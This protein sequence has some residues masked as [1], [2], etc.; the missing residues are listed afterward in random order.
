MSRIISFPQAFALNK[1]ANYAFNAYFTG[2]PISTL[3]RSIGYQFTQPAFQTPAA[4]LYNTTVETYAL[5]NTT[6][7]GSAGLIYNKGGNLVNV[8][9]KWTN[10]KSIGN[11]YQIQRHSSTNTGGSVSSN[12]KVLRI[13]CGDTTDLLNRSIIHDTKF[14][15]NG[16]EITEASNTVVGY[17]QPTD[18]VNTSVY[19]KGYVE[20]FNFN[21]VSSVDPN[22]RVGSHTIF[23]VG[24]RYLHT[25][26]SDGLLSSVPLDTFAGSAKGWGFQAIRKDNANFNWYCIVIADIE[27]S[28][29]EAGICYAVDTGVSAFTTNS[30]LVQ[31]QS[32]TITW[33]V[34]GNQVASLDTTDLATQGHT[35]FSGIGNALYACVAC[36]KGGFTNTIPGR[37]TIAVQEAAVFRS[38]T[39][40]NTGNGGTPANRFEDTDTEV[41]STDTDYHTTGVQLLKKLK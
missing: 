8:A 26:S 22:R 25:Q 34:N 40:I 36:L 18:I 24:Y 7:L 32:G 16:T 5:S 2:L 21:A 27:S 29:G 3:T 35:F 4:N 17:L 15:R 20:P 14:Q 23:F 39:H 33:T 41:T 10:G 19:F 31:Y 30:L 9:I 13:T 12:G 6:S 1:G 38:L 37:F 28:T 11:W